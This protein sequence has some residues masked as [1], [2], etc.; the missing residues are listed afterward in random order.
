M[1][2]ADGG[3]TAQDRPAVRMSKPLKPAK[4]MTVKQREA[5]VK[6]DEQLAVMRPALRHSKPVQQALSGAGD[7]SRESVLTA[8]GELRT[9]A[10]A[11]PAAAAADPSF[12]GA[13]WG[14]TYIVRDES[15]LD[16]AGVATA[17][18]ANPPVSPK[19]FPNYRPGRATWYVEAGWTESTNVS[20]IMLRMQ[21]YRA[22][23]NQLV[24]TRL[25]SRDT[26]SSAETNSLCMRWNSD[27]SAPKTCVWS[28]RDGLL[29]GKAGTVYYAKLSY[30][31]QMTNHFYKVPDQTKPTYR[32]YWLPTKWTTAVTS[33]GAPVV[34][35]PGIGESM[36]G[37]CTCWYQ[38]RI[39]D[40]VNTATGAVTETVTDA[41]L[42]GRGLPLTLSPVLLV[43]RNRHGRAAGQ[44]LETAI[45]G[46]PEGGRQC[47]HPDRTGRR[48]GRVHEAE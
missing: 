10:A 22:S 19:V 41:V 6:R 13:L 26:L 40:P 48:Q 30:A 34:Y 44:G 32:E 25:T 21:L 9:S 23:D 16:P 33:P 24:A 27:N 46:Q 2:A 31:T 20:P 8:D 11:A 39:A 37:W 36:S 28:L 35:T 17:L 45:R 15:Q 38:T 14:S 12:E 18:K 43:G 4:A 5:Q 7:E 42:S 3:S 1:A 47:R 29:V